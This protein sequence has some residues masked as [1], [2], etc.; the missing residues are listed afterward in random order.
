MPERARI[1]VLSDAV[2][3]KIAAGEV[4][5]RPASVLKELVENALDAKASHV[6][7]AVTAG[8][9]EAVIV[10]D[11]GQGM[12]RDDALLS[13]ERHATS[14]IA[15]VEDI[16]RIGTFGFRG[17]ALAAIAAVSRMTLRS[18][19][20]GSDHGVEISSVGGR[21]QEV[22]ETGG[23]PGTSVAVRNLFFNVP[24]RR[25]FL[26]SDATELSHMRHIFLL[27]AMA[28]PEVSL[29]LSV[30]DREVC[31]A[32]ASETLEDRLRD[33][34]PNMPPDQ[35]RPVRGEREGVHISGYAG[36][37]SLS[38]GDRS[39]QYLFVNRRPVSSPQ[40]AFAVS[41]VYQ[42]LL[43]RGRYPVVFL[44]IEVSPEEVDVNVH[45]TKKEVRFRHGGRV[46]DAVIETVRAALVTSREPS[47]GAE[48]ASAGGAHPSPTPSAA[49]FL[50]PMADGRPSH[51]FLYPR[52]SLSPL[53]AAPGETVTTGASPPAG[54]PKT[55]KLDVTS[56]PWSWCRILG[57]V[58]GLF[59]VL[60]TED[61]L[62]LMDP[63]AAHE[64]VLYEQF[65]RQVLSGP[66]PSQGLLAPETVEVPS[67]L[68]PAVRHNLDVLE[69]M[70]FG[71]A[72][73]GDDVFIVD[74]VP[75]ALGTISAQELLLEAARTTEEGGERGGTERW[76]VEQ[77]ARAACRAAVKA[78]DSM[79]LE[80]IERLVVDLAAAEMPYT[81]PHGRPTMIHI[82][83]AELNRK[84]GRA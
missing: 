67:A 77:V 73:F 7:V 46:R 24:A 60:E 84:F 36:L 30:D 10:T 43:P 3:N 6:E 22:R 45:P 2:I 21:I 29:R 32:P 40:V 50:A 63:H 78:R 28:N 55:E 76:S 31:R 70:G 69:N 25:K 83:F 80:E 23:P 68:A 72:E 62:V 8:G 13:L 51:A 5:D 35:L 82:G 37:P 14:K 19:P 54:P 52:R 75:A 58:G 15:D 59:V 57:Q 71:I 27:Y 56:A 48:H 20:A 12:D 64:R 49:P 44:F 61:G 81:C 11:D 9:R 41:E 65:M 39:E 26:R 53:P 33:L 18:C 4:V 79:T 34:F 74:A 42:T 16:E 47:R 17:E 1:R 38:R 66:A